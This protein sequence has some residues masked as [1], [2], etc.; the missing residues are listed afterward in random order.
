[1][2]HPGDDVSDFKVG[3]ACYFESQVFRL[4]KDAPAPLDDLEV[5]ERKAIAQP[6]DNDPVVRGVQ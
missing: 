6:G 5:F 3:A 4:E 2:H 1:M